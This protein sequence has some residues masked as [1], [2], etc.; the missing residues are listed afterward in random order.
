MMNIAADL[1]LEVSL[2]VL[3]DASAAIGICRRNLAVGQLWIQERVRRGDLTLTKW[4][5]GDN[6]ADMLTKHVPHELWVRHGGFLGTQELSG[7]PASAPRIHP[8]PR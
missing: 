2:E 5:G 3:A 4:P 8:A 1:G 6:P 7:R